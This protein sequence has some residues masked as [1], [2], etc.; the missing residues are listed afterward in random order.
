MFIENHEQRTTDF[1][2]SGG[3]EIR[4]GQGVDQ[5]AERWNQ[6]TGVKTVQK[7]NSLQNANIGL[8]QIPVVLAPFRREKQN[9]AVPLGTALFL[10]QSFT[11]IEERQV[12][13]I[14]DFTNQADC[15]WGEPARMDNAFFLLY[16]IRWFLWGQEADP[17]VR[18]HRIFEKCFR[19]QTI[20][21]WSPHNAPRFAYIHN[22]NDAI[23][24]LIAC[25]S[26]LSLP[27]S[28]SLL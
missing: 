18:K 8:S 23:G 26:L 25:P 28:L 1:L 15:Y 9:S 19:N 6:K 2:L 22:N 16:K 7:I 11:G 21:F 10:C 17:N 27:P 4:Q 20:Q 13:H 5:I 3:S 14:P 12:H 24:L